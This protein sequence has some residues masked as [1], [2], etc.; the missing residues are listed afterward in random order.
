M[1]SFFTKKWQKWAPFG[2]M[3]N[4]GIA[5]LNS[6]TVWPLVEATK[7][8]FLFDIPQ[9]SCC[10]EGHA[11][12]TSNVMK[13]VQAR[14]SRSERPFFYRRKNTSNLS[15][16][17][18]SQR[19]VVNDTNCRCHEQHSFGDNRVCQWYQPGCYTTWY[20][21]EYQNWGVLPQLVA[22][23]LCNYASLHMLFFQALCCA[24]SRRYT[25]LGCKWLIR[26]KRPAA[27]T[28]TPS[29]RARGWR[30]TPWYL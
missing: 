23:L 17:Y 25:T 1:C 9:L 8:S 3:S 16:R 28:R 20:T 22:P 30:R 12:Y 13:R 19:D 2:G 5:R 29:V 14:L 24:L 11:V 10:R 21:L 6:S 7:P 15:T 27:S 18:V 4:V 26:G